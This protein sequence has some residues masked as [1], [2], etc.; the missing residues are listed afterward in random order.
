MKARISALNNPLRGKILVYNFGE[1]QIKQ[2]ENVCGKTGNEL[3]VIPKDKADE[4]VG[5]LAG[6]KG[7]SSSGREMTRGESCVVFSGIDSKG[8]DRVL[9]AMKE[10]GLGGIPLKA[11]VTAHNQKMSLSEL[12]DELEKEHKAMNG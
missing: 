1:E 7:F 5:F 2:F 10:N 8:L 3:S 11:I 6:F 4:Q 9:A 12:I